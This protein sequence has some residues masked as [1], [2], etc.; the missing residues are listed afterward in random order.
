[1][2]EEESL[3]RLVDVPI[4]KAS[5][6]RNVLN[7]Q[8]IHEAE[9]G[10]VETCQDGRSATHPSLAV[11]FS[12]RDIPAPMETVF[13]PPMGSVEI[14]QARTGGLRQRQIRDPID[15]LLTD[16]AGFEQGGLSSQLKHLSNSR[17]SFGN[18]FIE[19]GATGDLPMFQTAMSLVPRFGLSSL[20]PPRRISE[21][22][23]KIG[24][25]RGLIVF[26]NQDVKA[27]PAVN[28]RAQ[29][30][31]RMH[32]IQRE[33]P[34]LNER[35]REERLERADLILLLCHVD[36]EEYDARGHIVGTELMDGFCLL[37]CRPNGF[38]VNGYVCVLARPGLCLQAAWLVSTPLLGFPSRKEGGKQVVEELGIDDF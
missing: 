6:A 26:G 10:T 16:F 18:P 32:R 11:I 21:K 1:M 7:P 17:P 38:A 9:D 25:Q 8:T 3:D 4:E 20:P 14:S 37:A 22:I 31:L 34:S 29:V 33:D 5:L 15:G 2:A 28:L 24:R 12:K 30:G 27:S 13:D 36:L 35:R 19:F 23:G